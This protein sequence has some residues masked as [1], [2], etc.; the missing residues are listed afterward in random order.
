ML[1]IA[2]LAASVAV[3]AWFHD[4]PRFT[5]NVRGQTLLPDQ[6]M[7][8]V[9][10]KPVASMVTDFYWIRMVNLAAT[11]KLP[12]EGKQ[13]IK[14]GEFVT[15]LEPTFFYAYMVGGLLGTIDV[16]DETWNVDEAVA[17]LD[18]GMRTLPD[19]PRLAIYQSFLLLNMKHDPAAAARVLE[20]A[21]KSPRAPAYLA[22]LAT[23]LYANA[24]DF[25]AATEFARQVSENSDDETRAFF[26][27]RLLEI[28]QEKLLV[29]V[30]DAAALFRE[31]HGRA[32]VDL[33]ELVGAKL[34]PGVPE[35]P[36]GGTISLTPEGAR[37][38]SR[39]S[40]LRPHQPLLPP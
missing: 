1:R 15:D 33:D 17:L 31:A 14:W 36:L 9:L 20:R 5:H 26:T 8:R 40:R 12:W 16:G 10:S 34:L 27:T 39:P 38:S 4:T 25:D 3:I 11:A 2:L 18:K 7:V 19:E 32:A 23:R 24:G 28:E 13:V 6:R 35:D 29:E 22:Q 37:A 30:D 21:S